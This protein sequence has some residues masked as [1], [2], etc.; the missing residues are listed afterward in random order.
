MELVKGKVKVKNSDLEIWITAGIFVLYVLFLIEGL[1]FKFQLDYSVIKDF[2]RSFEFKWIPQL[3]PKYF[4]ESSLSVKLEILGNFAVFLPFGCFFALFEKPS[5]KRLLDILVI[6]SFSVFIEICQATF[7]I[8]VGDMRDVILNTAGG[9]VGI[10][11]YYLLKK[12]F[13]GHTQT[14]FLIT[15]GVC[16]VIF[17]VL[18]L[19]FMNGKI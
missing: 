18:G 16:M 7:A 8:G 19:G 2:G 17:T 11:L 4:S 12:I 9:V 10:G 15:L 14:V 1:L 5:A 3:S 13:K 6:A